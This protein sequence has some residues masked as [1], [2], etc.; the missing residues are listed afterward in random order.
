M[1]RPQSDSGRDKHG[2]TKGNTE[3]Q[4]DVSYNPSKERLSKLLT[5]LG[6]DIE[7]IMV[8]VFISSETYFV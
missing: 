7:C 4:V 1:R 2:E 6:I 5:C 3:V 8:F